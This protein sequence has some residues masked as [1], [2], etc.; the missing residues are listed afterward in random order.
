MWDKKVEKM[1][2]AIAAY[3]F[4]MIFLFTVMVAMWAGMWGDKQSMLYFMGIAVFCLPPAAFFHDREKFKKD[5]MTKRGATP[6]YGYYNRRRS[7]YD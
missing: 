3:T 6:Q 2:D 4:M 7:D 5:C 1:L